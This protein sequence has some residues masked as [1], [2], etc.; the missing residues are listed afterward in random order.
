MMRRINLHNHTTFSD[1]QKTP[2]ELVEEAID[3]GLDEIAITDHYEY[4]L[5]FANFK[6]NIK[7]YFTV[8][9][10]LKQK[11]KK[12]KILAGVEIDFRLFDPADLPI[13]YYKD[14]DFILF[15]RVNTPTEL[16][17]LIKLRKEIPFKVGLAHPS[18]KGFINFDKLVDDLEKNKIFVELNT[19]CF[20]FSD[21]D[22]KN[23]PLVFETREHFFKL[24]KNRK[25][26]V[27]IGADVHRSWDTVDRIDEAY[28]FLKKMNLE[29]NLIEF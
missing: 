16:A 5:G 8:L 17:N 14:L 23:K 6:S 25:V 15:E 29:D 20:D 18:L 22:A 4:F 2:K 19:A 7:L 10:H 13:E 24:L 9:N 27:S 11:Y 21:R 1:G 12:I 3:K 26:K 28:D